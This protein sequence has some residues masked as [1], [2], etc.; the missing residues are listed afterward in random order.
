[1]TGT[2]PVV[3]RAPCSEAGVDQPGGRQVVSRALEQPVK[4]RVTRN[5]PNEEGS[6]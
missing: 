1:M 2:M 4:Y 5:V 3:R 6:D